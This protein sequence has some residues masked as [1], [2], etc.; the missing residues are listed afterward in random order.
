MPEAFD[1]ILDECIDRI[2]RGDSLEDC[3]AD[4]PEYTQQLE[5]FLQVMLEARETY[6]F[7]PSTTAKMEARQRFNAALAISAD[8][9]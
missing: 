5:P 2:N 3:L 1:K 7:V 4:Y 6:A 8:P 9:S